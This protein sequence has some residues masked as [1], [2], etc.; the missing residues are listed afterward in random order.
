MTKWGTQPIT[1]IT[2]HPEKRDHVKVE[3]EG[4]RVTAHKDTLAT[5]VKGQTFGSFNFASCSWET[6]RDRELRLTQETARA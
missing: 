5:F 6:A 4:I 1:S 3:A 2:Q